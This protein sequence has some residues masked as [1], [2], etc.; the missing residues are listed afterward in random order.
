MV[1]SVAMRPGNPDGLFSPLLLLFLPSFLDLCP[2]ARDPVIFLGRG[3]A[4]FYVCVYIYISLA[5][6]P[7][8]LV[9][10][11]RKFRLDAWPLIALARSLWHGV[12]RVMVRYDTIYT[13]DCL[14][15]PFFLQ[16]FLSR[17]ESSRS[18]WTE[19]FLGKVNYSYFLSYFF[20][21]SFLSFLTVDV[22]ETRRTACV[23][24]ISLQRV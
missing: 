10:F 4:L 13:Y 24:A 19:N 14:L 7:F 1:E 20:F 23:R 6:S 12:F 9:S 3:Y 2:L 11:A 22:A 16:E 15:Q 17:L 18:S 8:R 21:F 5:R